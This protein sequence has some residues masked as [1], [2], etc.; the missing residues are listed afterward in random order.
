MQRYKCKIVEKYKTTIVQEYKTTRV[1]E[2][3]STKN[4]STRVQE[5]KSTRV[6]EYKASEYKHAKEERSKARLWLTT[7]QVKIATDKELDYFMQYL[8]QEYDQIHKKS[9]KKNQPEISMEDY[10][11]A[12]EVLLYSRRAQLQILRAEAGS[13]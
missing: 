13:R 9:C 10:V 12:A 6:Q 2:Y 3:K 7:L 8:K 1:L 5:Y 11:L 4:K